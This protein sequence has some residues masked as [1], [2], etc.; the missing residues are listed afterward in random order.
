M[1]KQLDILSLIKVLAD[2]LDMVVVVTDSDLNFPGPSVLY[3]NPAYK[4]MTGYDPEEA[5]GQSPRMLQGKKT[6]KVLLKQLSSALKKG[7]HART[8][9]VNYRKNGEPYYC[10]IAAWPIIDTQ[11][12]ITHFIAL[13][14]EVERKRGRPRQDRH[15]EQW[16]LEALKKE[17]ENS[18]SLS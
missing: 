8:T 6:N 9:V 13:E 1:H 14:R 10:D 18:A 4:K 3:A 12:N 17:A 7:E 11:G 15:E 2:P 5:V 16:W